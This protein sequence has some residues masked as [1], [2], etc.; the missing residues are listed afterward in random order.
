MGVEHHLSISCRKYHTQ[1]HAIA[2]KVM[3]NIWLK[4]WRGGAAGTRR[5]ERCRLE[6]ERL[7]CRTL[8]SAAPSF[9]SL[10]QVGGPTPFTNTSDIPGQTGTV[11]LNSEVEPRIAVDPTNPMHLVGVYQQDRWSNGGSRGIVAA[12]STDGG[13][14]WTNVPLPGVSVN[15]G[16]SFPRAS[17]PWVSIGPDGTVYAS[18]LPLNTPPNDYNNGIYVSTSTDGGFTWSA[19]STVTLNTNPSLFNDKDSITADPTQAGYAYAVWDRLNS[20]AISNEGPGPTLFSRTTD[21]GKTWSAPLD[22][23]DPANGQ[24]IAN[25]LIVLPN[26]TL[27]NMAIHIDYGGA[28]DQIVVVRSTDKGLTWS[29]PIVVNNELSVGTRDPDTGAGVRAGGGIPDI[30]VDH[31]SGNLYI[32]WQDGRLSNS[33]YD[34]VLLSESTDG[35]LTWGAPVKVNQTP[36]GL[37]TADEQAFTPSIAVSANGEIAVTYYDFRNNTTA[38]GALTDA[39]MVFANPAQQPIAFGNEQRLTPTSFDMELAPNAYGYFLGDY[40]G[41]TAGGTSGDTFGAFFGATVSTQDPTSIFFRG[42]VPPS[43]LA[44][45]QFT[46]PTG[47]VEGQ[48]TG[49]TL[50]TFTDVSLDHA[51]SEYTAVVTWGDGATST[52]TSANGGIVQNQDGSFSV[53]ATHTYAEELSGKTFSVQ[54]TDGGGES[55]GNSISTLSVADASLTPAAVTI[56][57]TEGTAVTSATVATFTDADPAGLAGDYSAAINWGDGDTTASVS[58]VADPS[59]AGQFDVIASKSHPYTEGGNRT[60]TVSI[61]DAGGSTVTATSTAA[62]ADY[63]LTGSSRTLSGREGIILAGTLATFTDADSGEALSAY[64]AVINWGD[65]ATAT[66]TVFRV[67]PTGPLGVR[68][69]HVYKEA[70]NYP[71]QVTITDTGSGKVVVSSSAKVSDAGLKGAIASFSP[72][73]GQPFS[74]IVATF[75]DANPNAPLSDF[76]ATINWGDGKTTPATVTVDPKGGFDVNGTHTYVNAGAFSIT[77]NIVDVDGAKLTLKGTITVT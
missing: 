37:P 49:G 40:D 69:S 23:L 29:A 45:T 14:T 59:V 13:N 1:E 53:V 7:E 5:Q 28:P 27:V 50:A 56:Q 70:G 55:I 74:G 66:G 77:V 41:T 31:T 15:T 2:E 10:V 30:A 33:A 9:G 32:V 8:L 34:D 75:T 16:G 51:L 68:G 60:V 64:T 54:I 17:D 65:G 19:P 11:Y 62:V 61:S 71:I 12:V 43:P 44:L 52:L 42:A 67:T 25:Q 26:G 35:G 4:W 22:I 6:L 63:A 18:T 48:S 36:S 47:A 72:Q 57:A 39:W 76:S 21:G 3:G 73:H 58:V 24:T 46:P 38:P 20:G